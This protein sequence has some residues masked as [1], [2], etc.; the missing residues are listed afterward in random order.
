MKGLRITVVGSSNIDLLARVPRFPT[1]GETLVGHSFH[2]GF[3]G[4]GANQAVMAA[5]LGAHVTM[6]TKLGRDVFGQMTLHNYQQQGIDTEHVLFDEQ[7]ASGVAP[8]WVDETGRN[9]IVIV[10]GANLGLSVD[11][12]RAARRAIQTADVLLCQLEIPV[13]T[14]QEALRIAREAG[15]RTLFN[16]APALPIPDVLLELSDIVCPNETEAALLTGLPVSTDAQAE[17][18]ARRLQ[19]RGA[20]TVVLTR[21]ERGALIVEGSGPA[22]DVPGTAVQAVDTAGAGDAFLGSLATFLAEG[23]DLVGAV[24]WANEVAGESV[25]RMGTQVSFPRREQVAYRLTA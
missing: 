7:R 24:R 4:K 5:L 10:P 2:I 6:I 13:P 21:G 15:V 9:Q 25:T 20:G 1:V 3:G 19:H 12:V 11:E 8:I 18:A 16:P 22:V 17:Q 23:K 14:M